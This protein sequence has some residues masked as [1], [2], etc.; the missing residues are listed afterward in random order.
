MHSRERDRYNGVIDGP[1]GAYCGAIA[2]RSGLDR[3]LDRAEI[4]GIDRDLP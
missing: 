1:I 2:V 4:D 3:D